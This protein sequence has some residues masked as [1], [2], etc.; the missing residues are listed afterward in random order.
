MSLAKGCGLLA[1]IGFIALGGIAYCGYSTYSA[2]KTEMPLV[3]SEAR[4]WIEK[5]N[6]DQFSELYKSADP[7]LTGSTS[8][9]DFIT[10]MTNLKDQFGVLKLGAQVGFNMNTINN[11]TKVVCRYDATNEKGGRTAVFTFHK[12]SGWKLVGFQIQQRL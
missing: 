1:L 5:Y 3:E 7:Q 9:S 4:A 10:K 11:D 12:S 6:A 2:M 8:E